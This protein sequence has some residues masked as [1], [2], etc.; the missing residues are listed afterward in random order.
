MVM[1]MAATSP[2]GL[3]QH[4]EDGC[5]VEYGRRGRLDHVQFLVAQGRE[6]KKTGAYS[7]EG[8]DSVTAV[9]HARYSFEVV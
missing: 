7:K 3:V 9:P 2:D 4:M 5:I 8:K 1:A 6:D